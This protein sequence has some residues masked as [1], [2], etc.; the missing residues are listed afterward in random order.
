VTAILQ[1][2]RLRELRLGVSADGHG[3]TKDALHSILRLS[4]LTSLDMGFSKMRRLPDS[5]GQLRSLTSL[6]LGRLQQPAGAA[7]Q[8]RPADSPEQP[9]P[10]WLLEPSA[11]S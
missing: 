6:N 3:D 10:G 8:H 5:I 9:G 1:L 7:R 11:A 4:S 2:T